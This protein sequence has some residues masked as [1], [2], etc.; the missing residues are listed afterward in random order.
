[1]PTVSE[2]IELA[3]MSLSMARVDVDKAAFRGPVLDPL[4]P[5]KIMILKKSVKWAYEQSASYE[6][7]PETGN[8]LYA[9]LDKYGILATDAVDIATPVD[10]G[11]VVV[12][13]DDVP[14]FPIHIDE[15]DFDESDPTFYADDRLYGNEIR[16]FYNQI[17]RYLEDEEFNVTPEGLFIL[18]DGFDASAPT[19]D[20]DIHKVNG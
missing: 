9:M 11:P 3:E 19:C 5:Q 15:T 14:I 6:N 2:T 10:G 8:F 16:V 4:L 12:I 7:L 17:P 20:F 1:M 18:I 13:T